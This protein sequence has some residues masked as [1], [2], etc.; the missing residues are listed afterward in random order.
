V[1][2]AGEK[3]LS[4]I[5][6][7]LFACE[8]KSPNVAKPPTE[9]LGNGASRLETVLFEGVNKIEGEEQKIAPEIQEASLT[10]VE[11]KEEG[12]D[13]DSENSGD[14]ESVS[15]ETTSGDKKESEET[16][17]GN[18]KFDEWLADKG[19]KPI[20]DVEELV[21]TFQNFSNYEYSEDDEKN[22]DYLLSEKLDGFHLLTGSAYN[23]VMAERNYYEVSAGIYVAGAT[24]L[25][26]AEMWKR[27]PTPETLDHNGAVVFN[28]KVSD[29]VE[30]LDEEGRDKLERLIS[31][32]NRSG[33]SGEYTQAA[34]QELKW[35]F[36]L[37]Y[38][39]PV[40][41][42]E[43]ESPLV[44]F[45]SYSGFVETEAVSVPSKWPEIFEERVP[46][47]Q[48][49][50]DHKL[51]LEE[52][53]IACGKLG[54]EY[55]LL[56]TS[57][58]D[59]C[60]LR[61]LGEYDV[62]YSRYTAPEMPEKLDKA[63]QV[64]QIEIKNVLEN[65]Q[66]YP[67]TEYHRFWNKEINILLREYQ[68]AKIQALREKGKV[69]YVPELNLEP[70]QYKTEGEMSQDV[71]NIL[72]AQVQQ[73]ERSSK[74]IMYEVHQLAQSN[75]SVTRELFINIP[76]E[77]QALEFSAQAMLFAFPE[78]HAMRSRVSLTLGEA[79]AHYIYVLT[80]MNV[81]G[82]EGA[83]IL[84]QAIGVYKPIAEGLLLMVTENAGEEHQTRAQKALDVLNGNLE[85][86]IEQPV[87]GDQQPV[88]EE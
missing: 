2:N 53:N 73:L 41:Q 15:E 1:K 13:K 75:E 47:E 16:G 39:D 17:T 52:L 37:D 6:L 70:W 48:K 24:E 62:L 8:K 81:S 43:G 79:Y 34:L 3:M 68:Y 33:L 46:V 22:T 11:N 71:F 86:E 59:F 66:Q 72:D 57:V 23:I 38:P 4:Y 76:E 78:N 69:G 51:L 31:H 44:V 49:M 88:E 74:L 21:V 12:T 45:K 32:Y 30:H 60:M 82:D 80:T 27:Y 7:L 83:K 9:D 26:F 55:T 65:V 85:E 64:I 67:E 54:S 40:I 10:A 14:T 19:I 20:K 18:K 29:T 87:E 25:R 77:L 42:I 36:P 56:G 84:E 5:L 58:V 28:E 61:S 63:Q 35:R 50:E